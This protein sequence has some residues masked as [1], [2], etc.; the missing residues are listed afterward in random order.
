MIL[1]A[2]VGNDLRRDDG[3]GIVVVRRF[4]EAGVPEGVKVL[5]AGIAGLGLVQELMDGYEALVIVDATDRGGEPGTVYLLE[6]EVPDLEEFSPEGRHEYLTDMHYTVPSRALILARAMNILPSRAYILG[7][8]TEDHGLGMGLSDPVE[9][10]AEE[11]VGRLRELCAALDVE[12]A[13]AGECPG[14][15][16]VG[17]HGLRKR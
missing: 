11:A 4:Q 17:G 10:G 6:A 3:F 15:D 2:G 8:Q 5:E 9:R 13:P 16:G 1:V 14:P 7:C 12:R